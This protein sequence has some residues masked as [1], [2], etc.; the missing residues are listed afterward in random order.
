V[1]TTDAFRLMVV[2]LWSIMALAADVHVC[3][4]VGS[5]TR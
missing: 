5:N 3:V 4:A 2:D 1:L